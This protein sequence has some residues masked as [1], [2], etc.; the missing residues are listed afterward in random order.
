MSKTIDELMRIYSDAARAGSTFPQYETPDHRAGI[1]AVIRALRDELTSVSRL[2][3]VQRVFEEILAPR[4]GGSREA[5]EATRA[6]NSA[7]L[8]AAPAPTVGQRLIKAAHEAAAIARGE[9]SDAAPAVCVWTAQ[10][11]GPAHEIW[12]AECCDTM[13]ERSR[14]PGWCLVCR[15]PIKFTEAQR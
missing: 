5:G 15:A 13:F 10:D 2:R 9:V 6:D 11:T 7:P 3:D 14:S 1:A 12:K 8:P 4:E